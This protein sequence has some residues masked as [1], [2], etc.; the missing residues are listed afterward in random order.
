M[1][2]LLNFNSIVAF[3]ELKMKLYRV[4]MKTKYILRIL[5]KVQQKYLI[6]G[7]INFLNSETIFLNKKCAL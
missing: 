7:F 4:N 6:F 3:G 5:N 1:R 2:K